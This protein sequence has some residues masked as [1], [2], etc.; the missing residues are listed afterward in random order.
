MAAR[1][2]IVGRYAH[3]TMH[4]RLRLQPSVGVLALDFQR[5][6]LETGFLARTRLHHC[7]LVATLLR[8]ARIHA[9]QHLGP[10]L[11]FGTARAG[12]NLDIRIVAVRLA[13][14]QRF[15]RAALCVLAQRLQRALAFTDARLIIL[16]FAQF[17][18]RHRIV[19]ILLQRADAL[20][21]LLE[22]LALAHH[23]LRRLRVGPQVRVFSA[24]VQLRQSGFSGIPVKDASSGGS[25][26]PRWN[27][28]ASGIRRAS[29]PPDDRQ[30]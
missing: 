1:I 20:H 9:R 10:V 17:D 18:Q 14:E 22:L 15:D 30:N 24:P 25:A 19:E 11:A 13:V 28:R 26:P 3:Q 23:L 27:R 16:G 4:T 21:R 6:R 12:V 2:G 7:H 29:L 5:R 8:P